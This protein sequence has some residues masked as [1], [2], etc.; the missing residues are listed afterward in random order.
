MFIVHG[1]IPTHSN[2][3]PRQCRKLSN[4]IIITKP[5]GDIS[6]VKV[7]TIALRKNYRSVKRQLHLLAETATSK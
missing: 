7:K 4:R 2:R 1:T 5:N 3:A 6:A